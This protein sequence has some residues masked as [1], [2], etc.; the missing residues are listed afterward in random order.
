MDI[1]EMARLLGKTGGDQTLK[2]HGAE[3][4]KEISK[5][6]HAAKRKLEK[7]RKQIR[8]NNERI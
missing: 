1:K 3:Y 8:K 6:A 5:L 4:F 2:N 7:Q